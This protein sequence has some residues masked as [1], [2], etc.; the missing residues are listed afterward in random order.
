MS[1]P[2]TDPPTS[3]HSAG[4][5]EALEV[6][7]EAASGPLAG[8]PSIL[9]LAALLPGG[10]SLGLTLVGFTSAESVGPGIAI[11]L[12]ATGLFQLIA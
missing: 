2:V 5:H 4:H 10:T 6:E 3:G 8:D 1:T 7:P 9:G 11:F 12:V